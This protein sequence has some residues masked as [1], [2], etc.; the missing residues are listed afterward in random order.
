M[1]AV[2]K[3]RTQSCEG[4]TGTGYCRVGIISRVVRRIRGINLKKCA[5]PRAR[6]RVIA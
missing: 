3:T 6:R 1:S 4:V 2:K 5:E